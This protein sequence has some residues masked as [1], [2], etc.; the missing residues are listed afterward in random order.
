MFAGRVF[1][2]MPV[3]DRDKAV[4]VF[5]ELLN[6]ERTYDDTGE[7]SIPI[8]SRYHP[9]RAP[10]WNSNLTDIESTEKWLADIEV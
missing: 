3:L 9:E 2:G 6:R 8:G 4:K 7:Y 5:R 10:L 1:E